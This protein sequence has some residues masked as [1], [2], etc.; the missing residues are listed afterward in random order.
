M[1]LT[2]AGYGAVGQAHH[3]VF[4]NHYDIEIYDPFKGYDTMSCLLYTSPSPRD[5]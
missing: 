2:I 1:K 3:K 4:G 5:S